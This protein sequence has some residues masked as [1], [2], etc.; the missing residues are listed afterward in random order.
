M[1]PDE[2]RYRRLAEILSWSLM[3]LIWGLA[4]M[5]GV[6]VV[7]LLVNWKLALLVLMVVPVLA[8]LSVWFQVRIL[9]NYRSVRRIN[10]RITSAFNEG[11]TGA[12]TT[13]TRSSKMIT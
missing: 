3:D 8:W 2:Q 11:I 12:K 10:S 6:S 1:A 4:V 9:K 7:M 5:L 13:K